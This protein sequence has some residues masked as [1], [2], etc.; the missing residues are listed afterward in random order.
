MQNLLAPQSEAN[1]LLDQYK[2]SDTIEDKHNFIIPLYEKMS[3]E[4]SE[5]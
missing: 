1:I 4:N 2:I 3:K 5:K